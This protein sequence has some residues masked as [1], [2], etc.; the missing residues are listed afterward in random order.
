VKSDKR[1]FVL[2]ERNGVADEQANDRASGA[3]RLVEELVKIAPPLLAG[4][5]A[6]RV[7]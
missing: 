3:D 5:G 7:R 6:L 1:G 2:E 4:M